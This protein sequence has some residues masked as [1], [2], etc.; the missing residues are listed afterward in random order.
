VAA[1]Q[2]SYLFNGHSEAY[3]NLFGRNAKG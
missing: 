2:L 1:S 3:E